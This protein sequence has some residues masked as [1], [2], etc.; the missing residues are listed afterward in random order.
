MTQLQSEYGFER[1]SNG[2]GNCAQRSLVHAMLVLGTPIT[3]KDA[4]RRTERTISQTNISG[5]KAKDLIKGINR[6]NCA[7][8]PVELTDDTE[9]KSRIDEL[10]SEGYPVI[11][12][13][14]NASHWIVIAGKDE[15]DN[16]YWIDSLESKITG[17]TTWK[18]IR[19][20]AE[21]NGNYYFIGV[22][23]KNEDV[24][25]S[26]VS[27]FQTLYPMFDDKY[28][29]SKWGVYL[30]D[31][32]EMFDTPGED[33]ETITPEEFFKKYSEKITDSIKH[34]SG[35]VDRNDIKYEL[36]NYLRVAS[37]YNM[38]IPKEKEIDVLI[39]ITVSTIYMIP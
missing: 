11:L 19:F 39:D 28:F 35:V 17:R 26:L 25:H 10:L 36:N 30:E 1:Q 20:W 8:I 32:L 6:S 16:Y 12:H 21:Y 9:V 37:S 33:V 4:H 7:A 2:A 5:T 27:R 18:N 23:P 14:N 3:P 34:I 13:I 15:K 24:Q 38:R 29:I 22:K 31:L